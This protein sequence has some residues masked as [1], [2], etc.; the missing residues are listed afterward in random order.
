LHL[1]DSRTS[2]ALTQKDSKSISEKAQGSTFESTGTTKY[3]ASK[4]ETAKAAMQS[5]LDMLQ[6]V[7]IRLSGSDK[8]VGSSRRLAPASGLNN[9]SIN[10]GGPG[11]LALKGRKTRSDF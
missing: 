10:I 9:A 3:P 1:S 6:D 4:V 8:G 5:C 7:Q 11:Q 2:I